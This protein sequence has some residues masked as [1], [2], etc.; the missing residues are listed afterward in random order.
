MILRRVWRRLAGAVVGV[1]VE[2]GCQRGVEHHEGLPEAGIGGERIVD[3][4]LPA[5]GGRQ[6]GG[7]HVV[8]V[9]LPVRKIGREQQHV[10][11][12]QLVHDS[13]NVR[14][15][16]R[17]V[18]GLDRQPD[19]VA[20]EFLGR[21]VDPGHLVAHPAPELGEPPQARRQPGDPGFDQ[22]HLEL[23]V[24]DEHALA[25]EAAELG[26]EAQRLGGVVL[27]VVGRPPRAGERVVVAAA[28]VDADREA[29]AL[30]GGID[31]PV[32][33]LAERVLAHRQHH[34]LHETLVAGAPL[35][36]LHRPLD[37]LDGQHGRAQQARVLVQPFGRQP[38]VERAREGGGQVLVA[39][40]LDRKQR[41][42]DGMREAE[43]V[44]RLLGALCAGSV[45]APALR[46]SGRLV[47][48]AFGG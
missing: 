6:A 28:G 27:Q 46:Q 32:H 25:D 37:R 44:E 41:I 8:A 4:D 7:Q 22:H 43:A 29:V 42:A 23:G 9:E 33:R 17:R 36:L 40:G 15:R 30:G 12:L 3:Q 34:H 45:S 26:V 35:D 10:V 48:G 20:H 19:V 2:I 18:K 1:G 21:A 24:F 13:P 14:R 16:W 31:R 11:G 39:E 47:S 38:V 5:Q